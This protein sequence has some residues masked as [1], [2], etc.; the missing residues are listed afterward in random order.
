MKGYKELVA[1]AHAVITTIAVAAAAAHVGNAATVFIDVR[2]EGELVHT[3]IIPGALHVSRGL[4]E[5]V[6]DPASPYHHPI[7]GAAKTF[8]FY[9]ASGGRSAMATQRAQE[10]GLQGVVHLGGGLKAWQAAGYGL[11]PYQP[12]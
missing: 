3:G 6:I 4:L 8:I 9:C 12:S 7:F 11:D 5:L 10:M 1:E 2:C